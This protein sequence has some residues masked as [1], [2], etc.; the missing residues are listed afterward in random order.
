MVVVYMGVAPPRTI[1]HHTPAPTRPPRSQ[2]TV[3][4]CVVCVCVCV[5]VSVQV[6]VPPPPV[7]WEWMCSAALRGAVQCTRPA[8]AYLGVIVHRHRAR[9][10]T[11]PCPWTAGV[12]VSGQCRCGRDTQTRRADSTR[13]AKRNERTNRAA[14]GRMM[15]AILSC[16]RRSAAAPCSSVFLFLCVCVG[17]R[18]GRKR[19][20]GS[21]QVKSSQVQCECRSRGVSARRAWPTEDQGALGP[22]TASPTFRGPSSLPNR[23]PSHARLQSGQLLPT[24]ALRIRGQRPPCTMPSSRRADLRAGDAGPSGQSPCTAGLGTAPAAIVQAVHAAAQR[25]AR[26]KR[27]CALRGVLPGAQ[28][29]MSAANVH[30]RGPREEG[31]GSRRERTCHNTPR[32]ASGSCA[33]GCFRVPARAGCATNGVGGPSD[34]PAG[35]RARLGRKL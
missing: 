27:A 20:R 21:G 10:C 16:T 17:E 24:P 8:L 35:P 28:V 23:Q 14:T 31:G 12:G 13:H 6:T 15:S 9:P 32:A 7:A 30:P 4:V 5:Y 18:R 34:G 1:R 25:C 3:S 11:R 2:H 19:G 22:V 33:G 29:A 26:Y